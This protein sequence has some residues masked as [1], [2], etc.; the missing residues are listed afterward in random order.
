MHCVKCFD[1]HWWTSTTHYYI[2]LWTLMYQVQLPRCW[3]WDYCV[4]A[5]WS[6]ARAAPCRPQGPHCRTQPGPSP[7]MAAPQESQRKGGQTP[8]SRGQWG[9]QCEE[10]PCTD[11]KERRGSSKSCPGCQDFPEACAETMLEQVFMLQPWRTPHWSR[12]MYH[13]CSC[14]PWAGLMWE[15]GRKCEEGGA[16]MDWPQPLLSM[17]LH[18]SEEVEELGMIWVKVSLGKGIALGGRCFRF[19]LRFSSFKS[20]LTAHK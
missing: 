7:K 4:A 9:E 1:E 5:E 15:Q 8:H 11:G 3:Q 19:S 2:I 10:R 20:L 14:S 13:E 17:P 16:V 6:D 12:C 18:L